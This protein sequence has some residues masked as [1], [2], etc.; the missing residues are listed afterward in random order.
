MA[1][2]QEF[3]RFLV[4]HRDS[5]HLDREIR[6]EL[7]REGFEGMVKILRESTPKSSEARPSIPDEGGRS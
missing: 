2:L 6:R 4:V 1:R 5:D 7:H 3:F